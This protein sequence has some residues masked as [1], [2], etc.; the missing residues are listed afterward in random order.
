MTLKRFSK[1]FKR[2]PFKDLKQFRDDLCSMVIIVMSN[3]NIKLNRSPENK[4]KIK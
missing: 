1:E 3:G 2:N 4:D